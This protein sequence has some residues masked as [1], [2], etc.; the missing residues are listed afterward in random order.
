MDFRIL[1]EV[2]NVETIARGRGIR[3][4]KRLRRVYGK[5]SWRKRKGIAQ[6]KL[7]NGTVKLAELHWY[8]GTGLGRKEYKI[9]KYLG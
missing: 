5:V 9:K 3:E 1:S 7:E 6:I 8:E 4:L 2:S